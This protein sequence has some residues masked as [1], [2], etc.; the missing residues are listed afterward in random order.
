MTAHKDFAKRLALAIDRQPHV[1]PINHGRLRWFTEQL[2][3]RGVSVREETVRKWFAGETIPRQ[4]AL[5]ALADLLD[6]DSAW[7]SLGRTPLDQRAAQLRNAE[8]D[9][10]VNVLAGFIQMG[11]ATP[12]FPSESRD[13][14]GVVDITAIIR[15]ALYA[16]H[17]ALAREVGGAFY[18]AVPVQALDTTVVLGVIPKAGFAI[19]VL[20]LDA[21]RVL[22]EAVRKGDHFEVAMDLSYRTN[23]Q[24]WRQITTFSERI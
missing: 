21:R 11:G 2:E 20:E 19:D 15:G 8:A 1:P 23:G 17:I 7:L 9:G 3:A 14:E 13:D 4:K 22:A 16:L 18:F 10:V 6:A 5:L 24:A 12:A